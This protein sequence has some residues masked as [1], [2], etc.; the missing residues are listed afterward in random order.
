MDDVI[1]NKTKLKW[2]FGKGDYR[3]SSPNS[4]SILCKY[5]TFEFQDKALLNKPAKDR[6]DHEKRYIYRVIGGLKCFKRYPNVSVQLSSPPYHLSKI[7]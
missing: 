1:P 5:L 6:T 3:L 4:N 7:A 2:K